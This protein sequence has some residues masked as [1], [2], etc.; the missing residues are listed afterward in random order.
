LF[1]TSRNTTTNHVKRE[2][3]TKT[4][5]RKKSESKQTTGTSEE[6]PLVAYR[7]EGNKKHTKQEEAHI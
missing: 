7:K 6:K 4:E 1:D 3:D 5:Q 2:H